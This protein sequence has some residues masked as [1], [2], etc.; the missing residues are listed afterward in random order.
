MMRSL[1]VS[2]L[3]WKPDQIISI[4]CSVVQNYRYKTCVAVRLRVK[5]EGMSNALFTM[6][7]KQQFHK[8]VRFWGLLV[9]MVTIYE[10]HLWIW[11]MLKV[12]TKP[13]QMRYYMSRFAHTSFLGNKMCLFSWNPKMMSLQNVSLLLWKPDRII[14]ISHMVQIQDMCEYQTTCKKWRN[15]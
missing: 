3:P 7:L 12:L 10:R 4:S 6:E 14:L 9:T 5:S 15:F 1:S 13:F 2:Q 11:D 8:N